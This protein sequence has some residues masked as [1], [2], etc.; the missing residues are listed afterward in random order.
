MSK[1]LQSPRVIWRHKAT[2]KLWWSNTAT[3]RRWPVTPRQMKELEPWL[4]I[5]FP[6][7]HGGK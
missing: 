7:A 5:M 1:W 4:D 2:G 3:G 6:T